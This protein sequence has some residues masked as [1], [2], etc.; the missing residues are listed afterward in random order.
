MSTE[1]HAESRN[2]DEDYD[3]YAEK[4]II[5]DLEHVDELKAELAEWRNGPWVRKKD[6]DEVVERFSNLAK[7]YHRSETEIGVLRAAI[8]KLR[9]VKGRYNTQIATERLFA[10]VAKKEEVKS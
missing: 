4:A 7:A 6:H 3:N 8:R 5:A 9:D 1:Y 10:L 2:P